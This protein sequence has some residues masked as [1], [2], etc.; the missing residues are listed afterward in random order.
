MILNIPLLTDLVSLQEHWQQVMD[1][2]LITANAKWFSY[3]YK[4][5]EDVLKIAFEP[6][7]MEPRAIGSFQILQVHA[8]GTL[9]I[10]V[11]HDTIEHISLRRV[12]LYRREPDYRYGRQGQ[13]PHVEDSP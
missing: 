1:K 5:G 3:D 9:K 6:S 13:S 12:R 11:D 10:R 8:N 7:K 4:V 2:R